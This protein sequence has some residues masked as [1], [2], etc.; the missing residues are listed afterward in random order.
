MSA[1]LWP[2]LLLLDLA[3]WV[4]APVL[5]ALALPFTKQTTKASGL[6]CLPAWLSWLNT[7]D[8]VTGEQG[9][10]EPAVAAV[11]SYGW[12]IKTLYWLGV[13][14]T[15][16]GLWL[17]MARPGLPTYSSGDFVQTKGPY[18]AGVWF[19][20]SDVAWEFDAVWA[21]TAT[22]CGN[23]RL[24]WRVHDGSGT[25]LFQVRPWITIDSTT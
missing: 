9:M 4:I 18:R 6:S 15:F 16:G 3:S 12:Y 25:F 7:P 20:R 14:N 1:V 10:Y 23:V 2:L 13:R 22:K 21:W 8:D 5:V 19:G 24:G 11:M 17:Q